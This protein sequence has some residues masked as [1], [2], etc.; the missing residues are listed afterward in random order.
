MPHA[1]EIFVMLHGMLFTDIQL[2]D[3]TAA[4]VGFLEDSDAEERELT[5]MGALYISVLY[6]SMEGLH[7]SSDDEK[8]WRG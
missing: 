2:E 7:R 4:L 5:M 1:V 8:F 3:F 6:S